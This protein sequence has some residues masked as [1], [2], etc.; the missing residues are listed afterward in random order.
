MNTS[1]YRFS[2]DLHSTQSKVMIRAIVG[3]TGRRLSISLSDG[4]EPYFIRDGCLAKISIRRPSKSFAEDLCTIE[5]NSVIVYEFKDYTAIEEGVHECSLTLY[6]SKGGVLGTPRFTM[7]VSGRVVKDGDIEISDYDHSVIDAIVEAEAERQAAEDDRRDYYEKTKEDLDNLINLGYSLDV[8]LDPTDYVITL[9]L[10]NASGE[11]VSEV[12]VDLPLE[13]MVVGGYEQDGKIFLELKNGETVSFELGDFVEG[14]TPYIGSNGNWW[15]GKVDTG[16]K[17]NGTDGKSIDRIELMAIGTD[18]EGR[19]VRY[20]D[21]YRDDGGGAIGSFAITDG[22]DGPR[23]TSVSVTSVSESSADGGRNVVTFSD[24]TTLSVK[25]GSKGTP[26]KSAYDYAKD[27]GYEGTEAEF[28]AKLAEGVPDNLSAFFNDVGFIKSD[29]A[30][31]QSVNGKAGAV[32]LDASDVGARPSTWTP[33]YSDVGADKSGAAVDAVNTHNSN[34]SAHNDIRLLIEGLTA[35]LNAIANSDD[36]TLD[37]M[38]EVVDYIKANRDLISEI[39]TNKVNYSDIVNDLASNITN[40]PLSAAQG[41]AL[42]ALIDAITVPTKVSQLENDAKYLT[43]FTESDPTVPAWAKASTKPSYSKTEV[44]L[45]NVDNV[46]QYSASNPPPY[47]VISVNTKTGRVE[48]TYDDIGL[49]DEVWTFELEDGSTV[50]KRV[51][52]VADNAPT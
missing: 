6:D 35:R 11:P 14:I 20:Y 8:G 2:L 32:K 16:V 25:N 46:K 19:V 31:V 37:Q 50:T 5:N 34:A 30:P 28:I 41:V 17:A 29:E 49:E 24:G 39:T 48:L 4:N 1:N 21:V 38:K 23:G 27:G 3:D 26:G 7:E 42:K 12:R 40:K 36:T 13:S 51:A 45:G 15:T 52:L 22:K 18:A 44:G 47:P 33:T 9:I 10:K 43:S